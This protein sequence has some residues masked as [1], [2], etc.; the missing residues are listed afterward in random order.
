[1]LLRRPER[2]EGAPPP[3]DSPL[4]L[5]VCSCLRINECLQTF[6]VFMT[7]LGEGAD[8]HTGHFHWL[9]GGS[10]VSGSHGFHSDIFLESASSHSACTHTHTL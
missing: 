3:V 6:P 5:N 9:G 7:L 4:Q 8:G 1:M 10:S 2:D